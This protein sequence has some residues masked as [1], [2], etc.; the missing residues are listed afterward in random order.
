MHN[1]IMPVQKVEVGDE[2]TGATVIDPDKG[3]V[4]QLSVLIDSLLFINLC[5]DIV[6]VRLVFLC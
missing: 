4:G 6:G 3:F 1:L 2:F 5:N